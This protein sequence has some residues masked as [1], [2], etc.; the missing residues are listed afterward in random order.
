MRNYNVLPGTSLYKPYCSEVHLL[1][2]Y[3]LHI[4]PAVSADVIVAAREK[5]GRSFITTNFGMSLKL[6]KQVS[7]LT[8]FDSK[9]PN[10]LTILLSNCLMFESP[11]IDKYS[12]ETKHVS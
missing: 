11:C 6:A 12:Y 4:W 2:Q 9:Q 7:F 10:C 1:N 5:L 3:Y 8:C